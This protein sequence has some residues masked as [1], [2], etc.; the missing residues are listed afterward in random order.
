MIVSDPKYT[1]LVQGFANLCKLLGCDV[2]GVNTSDF[3]T[4]F[5]HPDTVSFSW[6]RERYELDRH[7]LC[8]WRGVDF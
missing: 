2:F 8:D 7:I 5:S 4:E 3:P 6:E 1:D